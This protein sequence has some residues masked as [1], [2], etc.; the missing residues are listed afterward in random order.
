MYDAEIDYDSHRGV[1]P[2]GNGL[3]FIRQLN[4]V[5]RRASWIATEM[6][7]RPVGARAPHATSLVPNVYVRHTGKGLSDRADLRPT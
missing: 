7:E 1:A 6:H 3:H 2:S 5:Q 4:P